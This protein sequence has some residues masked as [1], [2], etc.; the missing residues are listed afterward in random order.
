MKTLVVY[1][2]YS[3]RTETVARTIAEALDADIRRIEEVKPRNGFAQLYL[4][5]GMA[6]GRDKCSEIKPCDIDID[7]YDRI[8]IG[9]PNWASKP[10]PAVNAFITGTDLAGKEVIVFCTTGGNMGVNNLLA[11]FTGKVEDKCGRVVGSFAIRS[12]QLNDRELAEKA[13]EAL[14]GLP[15]FTREKVAA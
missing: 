6:A 13:R 4:D 7:E 5:G 10:A 15:V 11:N 12:S 14:L 3:G 9:T 8:F 1:Y 2:S